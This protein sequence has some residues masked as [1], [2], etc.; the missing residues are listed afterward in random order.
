MK[1]IYDI[2]ATECLHHDGHE[3]DEYGSCDS[4]RV[5]CPEINEEPQEGEIETQSMAQSRHIYAHYTMCRPNY[6]PF[7]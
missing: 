4:C 1:K 6:N 2:F 3:P 7:R 5:I